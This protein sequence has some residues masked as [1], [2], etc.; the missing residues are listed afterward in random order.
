MISTWNILEF[1]TY[2]SWL[3]T[4]NILED[5]HISSVN[6]NLKYTG[7]QHIC[8]L[9]IN[10]FLEWISSWNTRECRNTIE[11]KHF[12]NWKLTYFLFETEENMV[13]IVDFYMRIIGVVHFPYRSLLKCFHW[14]H[15]LL[16]GDLQYQHQ[17]ML[18]ATPLCF[19]LIESYY[20]FPLP[21]YLKFVALHFW[22][23]CFFT[24]SCILRNFTSVV[25]NGIKWNICFVNKT[26]DVTFFLTFFDHFFTCFPLVFN[27]NSN[28]LN[29]L[30]FNL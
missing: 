10:T 28:I 21:I 5:Q 7:I 12:S 22:F 3:L 8:K 4:W 25:W 16:T 14:Y 20:H 19:L 27:L 9:I 1:N 23:F 13:F 26:F 11:Y 30:E 2:A 15:L 18:R 29:W 6:F 24:F 17:M